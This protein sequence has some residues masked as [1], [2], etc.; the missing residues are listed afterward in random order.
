VPGFEAEEGELGD[1]AGQLHGAQ[2]LGRG[3]GRRQEGRPSP[4]EHDRHDQEPALL[5]AGDDLRRDDA[6]RQ[7]PKQRI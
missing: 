6:I 5:G 7:R 3:V 4:G 2:Q 1:Y